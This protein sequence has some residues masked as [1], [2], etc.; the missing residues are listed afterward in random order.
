MSRQVDVHLK[1]VNEVWAAR[2]G[3]SLA[4]L[5]ALVSP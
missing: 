4:F 5:D 2:V 1:D 3:A